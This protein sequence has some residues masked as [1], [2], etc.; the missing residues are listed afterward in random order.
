MEAAVEKEVLV[1]QVFSVAPRGLKSYCR[2][3]FPYDDWQ[4]AEKL[5]QHL[6]DHG[7]ED[8]RVQLSTREDRP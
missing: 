8:V 2:K 5:A 7:H 6:R 3:I 1:W 4:F